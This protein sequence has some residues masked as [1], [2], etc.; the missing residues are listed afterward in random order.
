MNGHVMYAYR[1]MLLGYKQ[2]FFEEDLEIITKYSKKRV[3]REHII[4]KT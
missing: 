4:I 1:F 3:F 2:I